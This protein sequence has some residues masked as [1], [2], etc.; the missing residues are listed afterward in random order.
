MSEAGILIVEDERVVARDMEASLHEWGWNAEV[1]CSGEEALEKAATARHDLALMDIRLKGRLDGV[2]TA[3]RLWEQ[4]RIPVV[5]VTGCAD[6]ATLD[7]A[8]GTNH[9]GFLVKPFESA[10][11][12]GTITTALQQV[13]LD[14]RSG[15]Q[16]LSLEA[17]VQDLA[18][19]VVATDAQGVVTFVNP[20]AEQLTG[21]VRKDALGRSVVRIL[22]FL[23]GRGG[24]CHHPVHQALAGQEAVAFDAKLTL[25]GRDQRR[26]LVRCGAAPFRDGSG[27]PGGALVIVGRASG[28][29]SAALPG[30]SDERDRLRR[31]LGRHLQAH[32]EQTRQIA[33]ELHDEAGQL[34]V[35]LHLGIED[36]ARALPGSSAR[37][38]RTLH[39]LVDEAEGQ[40]RLLSRGLRPATLDSLGLTAALRVLADG[41]NGR[42]G[43]EVSVEGEVGRLPAP[44]ET[45][46]Y[47]I[48]QEGLSN[49]V[50]H[51]RAQHARI[52][53]ECDAAELRC[54]ISDDGIGF[55]SGTMSAS[56]GL[57]LLGMQER[58]V[59]L[60]GS[61]QVCSAPGQGTQLFVHVPLKP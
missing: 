19:A 24:A 27:H 44:L 6:E 45:A 47:R 58:L 53:L 34:L 46:V 1:A 51:A 15:P 2:D 12:R 4:F 56:K 3:A 28:M 23:D 29:P 61:I 18:E 14:R 35:Q 16:G 32:E 30:V 26:T 22:H 8:R 54:T 11:L 59:P 55:Q 37:R 7:R 31:L 60:R 20:A 52:H 50:R 40:L 13:E 10:E 36:V 5:Y 41:V 9:L 49:V 17:A 42:S 43:V 33:R 21:W 48:A 38:V 39:A 25:V 57:G